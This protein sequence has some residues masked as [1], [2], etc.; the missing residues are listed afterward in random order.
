LSCRRPPHLIAT[1][2]RVSDGDTV[3]ATDARSTKLRIRLLGID[4]PEIAH[5]NKPGQPFGEEAR[6]YLD[7]LIGGKIVQVE[8][9]APTSTS[10]SWPCSGMA[11]ST[12]TC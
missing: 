10:G 3:T 6:Q 11:R 1:I 5:G 2:T 9:T 7:Y 12:S 4:A 8:R